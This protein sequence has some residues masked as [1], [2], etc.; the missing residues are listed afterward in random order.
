MERRT[1]SLPPLEE[2]LRRA[3]FMSPPCAVCADIGADHGLLSAALL[4]S[5]RAEHVLASDISEKSLTKARRLLVSLGLDDRATFAV[6]DGLAA[7]DA[8]PQRPAQAVFMLGMGGLALSRILLSGFQRLQGARLILGAQ[9][10]LPQ[11]RRS[12][13]RVGYRLRDEQAVW[14]KGRGYILM[15]CTPAENGERPYDERELLLGPVLLRTLPPEWKPILAKRRDILAGAV[16][17]MERTPR[18]ERAQRLALNQRE[19]GIISETLER[20]ER[21]ATSCS[22]LR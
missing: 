3:L 17:A 11:L 12:L 1:F 21:E 7:L 20:Y 8:L 16:E 14:E 2:R 10:D 19:L 6:A 9:T 18:A 15:G 5:G 22:A 4:Q 13:C